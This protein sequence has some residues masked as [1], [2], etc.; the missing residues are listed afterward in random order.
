MGKRKKPVHTF[1]SSFNE[2]YLK[3]VKADLNG[4]YKS[5]IIWILVIAS[6]IGI[7]I[8]IMGGAIMALVNNGMA[9]GIFMVV[10][11]IYIPFGT[12]FFILLVIGMPFL[13]MDN[14]KTRINTISYQAFKDHFV[15]HYEYLSIVQNTRVDYSNIW[16]VHVFHPKHQWFDFYRPFRYPFSMMTMMPDFED[17]AGF[18]NPFGHGPNLYQVYFREPIDVGTGRNMRTVKKAVMDIDDIEK[19]KEIIKKGG[20]LN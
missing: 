8:A 18:Y 10:F 19:F 11:G 15:C 20:G 12:F 16:Q 1:R 7:G 14:I 3:K 9:I 6:S 13:M 5:S 4:Q 17:Y 2:D